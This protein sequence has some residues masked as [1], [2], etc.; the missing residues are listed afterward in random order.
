MREDTYH[1]WY[2]LR[3]LGYSD[4]QIAQFLDC[5]LPTIRECNRL[6]NL[7]PRHLARWIAEERLNSREVIL[8]R[9]APYQW[10]IVG[11]LIVFE[12]F[13]YWTHPF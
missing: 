5:G 7:P 13:H 6:T 4:S 11:S 1:A 8:S 3:R 12:Y 2:Y 10:Y 9:I